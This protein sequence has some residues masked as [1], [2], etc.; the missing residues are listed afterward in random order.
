MKI[1]ALLAIALVTPAVFLPA[2]SGSEEMNASPQHLLG[3][4]QT[5]R[6]WLKRK[7]RER[8]VASLTRQ[9]YLSD[10]REPKSNRRAKL[11]RNVLRKIPQICGCSVSQQ[12]CS[13]VLF[14]SGTT[15]D[16][17]VQKTLFLSAPYC[18]HVA[19]A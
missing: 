10:A 4:P 11:L 1:S 5:D 14:T 6:A 2:H 8:V 7:S 18:W 17:P 12:N 13:I 19:C 16:Q 9:I 15:P 3:E